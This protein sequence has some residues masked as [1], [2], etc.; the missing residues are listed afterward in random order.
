[1]RT[2]YLAAVVTLLATLLAGC[3]ADSP[4]TPVR[5]ALDS[6]HDGV[7][8]TL[9]CAPQDRQAWQMLT[10]AA[11]DDDGDGAAVNA[12]GRL[13]VGAILPTNRLAAAV[14]TSDVDCDDA[15]PNAWAIRPYEGVD[16]DRD[17]HAVPGTGSKCTGATLPA[18][19]VATA[20]AP[21]DVDCNDDDARTWRVSTYAARDDDGDGYPVAASGSVCGNGTLSANLFAQAPTSM[22]VD[23]D[24]TDP[25][26]WNWHAVYRD[27]DGDGVGAAPAIHLC[28]GNGGPSAGY[29][30][31]GYDPNDD[32]GDPAAATISESA[33][34]VMMLTPS[35]DG[36]ED[37]VFL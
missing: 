3:A 16:S 32:P 5:Q 23:C 24:D 26:R 21:A 27:A 13:C 28:L 9:D 31:R 2:N 34:D 8:D 25:T 18:G 10:F 33:I 35:D 6:D 17:G 11:R 12:T 36:D 7:E 22:Q 14:A 30:T 19:F 15:D 29:V 1:M 4:E 37:D 20:P